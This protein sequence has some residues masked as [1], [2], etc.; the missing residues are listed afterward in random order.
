MLRFQN[1]YNLEIYEQLPYTEQQREQIKKQMTSSNKNNKFMGICLI[2][3]GVVVIFS[4]FS[5]IF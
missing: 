2:V 1:K 5:M 4:L 3:L